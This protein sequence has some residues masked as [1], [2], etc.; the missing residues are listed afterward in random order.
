MGDVSESWRMLSAAV[1]LLAGVIL[2]ISTVFRALGE[3]WPLGRHQWWVL[4]L[5]GISLILAGSR[6]AP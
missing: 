2:V 5:L 6:L 4:P 1:I 3:N